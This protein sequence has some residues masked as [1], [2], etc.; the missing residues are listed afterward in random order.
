MRRRASIQ[1]DLE[2]P[3]EQARAGASKHHKGQ[4]PPSLFAS[5]GLAC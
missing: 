4:L 3:S 1:S 5:C 2:R